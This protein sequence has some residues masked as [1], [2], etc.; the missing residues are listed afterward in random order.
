MGLRTLLLSGLSLSAF[1]A[2]G[3]SQDRQPVPVGPPAAQQPVTHPVAP[4]TASSNPALTETDRQWYT[5]VKSWFDYA[6]AHQPATVERNRAEATLNSYWKTLTAQARSGNEGSKL[7]LHGLWVDR[8]VEE[9]TQPSPTLFRLEY[10]GYDTLKQQLATHQISREQFDTHLQRRAIK[11]L[12]AYY[13]SRPKANPLTEDKSRLYPAI[14]KVLE[15][16]PDSEVQQWGGYFL[17]HFVADL[18]NTIQEAYVKRATSAFTEAKTHAERLSAMDSLDDLYQAT[19]KGT[20]DWNRFLE[21]IRTR[22]Q[23]ETP[24]SV[25]DLPEAQQPKFELVF[26]GMIQDPTASDV[27]S[28]WLTPETALENQYAAAWSLG[29]IK[30]NTGLA[31]LSEAVANDKLDPQAREMALFSLAEYHA[32]FSKEVMAVI[33]QYHPPEGKASPD[34]PAAPEYLREAARAMREKIQYRADTEADFYINRYLKTE[35]E[36]QTYRQN[37]DRYVSGLEHLT[38]EQRNLVDRALLPYRQ[39]L[40]AIL[41]NGGRHVIQRGVVGETAYYRQKIGMR[42][43]DGRLWDLFKGV[44]SGPGGAVT[45]ADQIPPGGH[46]TFAHEFTHH[47]HQLVLANEWRVEENRQVNL[48]EKALLLYRDATRQDRVLDYYGATNEYEYLA[49]GGEALDALYKKHH[50]LYTRAFNGGYHHGSDNIR[51]KLRRM[52]PALYRFLESLRS[53][54]LEISMMPR[55]P[56]GPRA[57]DELVAFTR[58]LRDTVA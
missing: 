30:T 51:S 31:A 54:P 16:N 22:L 3:L 35:T 6:N 27:V 50:Y 33:D 40:P 56:F 43:Q 48:G 32:N 34:Q 55:N 42:A 38:L 39:W 19:R 5:A 20:Y 8:M 29:R 24:A 2:P 23:T 9:L 4:P 37:R 12:Y 7:V 47:L 18:P 26:L 45:G 13:T 11:G 10:E 17:S 14:L 58:A 41:K 36:R 53:L 1:I 46:N 44:S 49:Q 25:K 57:Q 21:G 52:D 15:T 28:R